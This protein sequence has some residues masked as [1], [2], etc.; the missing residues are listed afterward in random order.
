MI[1]GV[2]AEITR[3]AVVFDVAGAQVAHNGWR[4]Y[5]NTDDNLA[6]G[7]S[8]ALGADYVVQLLQPGPRF[9]A[10][11]RADRMGW[12]EQVGQASV[13]VVGAHMIVTV[14]LDAIG[15][16]HSMG[17]ALTVFF[18]PGNEGFENIN[19]HVAVEVALN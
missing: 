1:R 13:E 15:G 6:T 2:R 7:Y 19:G 18:G 11:L 5:L 8:G 3:R 9:A 4:F 10:I 12:H 16:S 14:P 17:W